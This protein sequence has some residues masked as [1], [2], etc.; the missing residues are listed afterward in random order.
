MGNG[1]HEAA[2]SRSLPHLVRCEGCDTKINADESNTMDVLAPDGTHETCEI[3][4]DCIQGMKEEHHARIDGIPGSSLADEIG[5]FTPN[6][7]L[8]DGY[9]KGD[10]Q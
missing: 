3:C 9:R 6:D 2:Y 10:S 4:D 5:R 8:T 7:K 1:K